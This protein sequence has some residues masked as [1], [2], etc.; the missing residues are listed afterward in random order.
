MYRKHPKTFH[1]P[2]SP[3]LGKEDKVLH[4]LDHFSKMDLVVASVK[5]D[6][7][8]FSGYSDGKTHARSLDSKNHASRNWAKAFWANTYRELPPG[9]RIQCEN[10]YAKHAIHYENLESYLYLIL[11]W[12]E[13]NKA[14]TWDETLFWAE[15][16]NIPPVPV[17]YVGKFDYTLIQKLYRE[18]AALTE[19]EGYVIR[20]G[21]V[22]DFEDFKE[23][24]G[25]W[26]RKGH[27][28]EDDEHWMMKSIVQ[29]KLTQGSK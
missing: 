13:K 25:K 11:V 6:G 24:T 14:I 28:Q 8:A 16:L 5:M 4:S 17:F 1:L 29:N 18:Q 2:D 10:V 15:V 12:N 27:V 23:N 9:W 26:V 22:F 19:T 7:E 21:D 20:N 3:G